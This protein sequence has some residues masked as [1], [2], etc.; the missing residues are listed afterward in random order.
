MKN[1]FKNLS[2]KKFRILFFT[3]FIILFC[4]L[5]FLFIEL[6]L[7]AKNYVFIEDENFFEEIKTYL[8]ISQ[9]Q[10]ENS[11]TEKLKFT[12]I[13][14]DDLENI[15]SNPLRK[16]PQKIAYVRLEKKLNF[17]NENFSSKVFSWELE[18]KNFVPAIEADFSLPKSKQKTIIS[19]DISLE[20]LP[21]EK[22]EGKK[23]ALPVEKKYLGEE[24]Y[25]L[26]EKTYL[27][28]T[29]LNEKF[30]EELKNFFDRKFSVNPETAPAE[31]ESL[32]GE[33]FSSS[34]EQKNEVPKQEDVPL[35]QNQN[36]IKNKKISFVA[37]VGDVMLSRGV[38]EIL[39]DEKLGIKSVFTNTLPV[40]QSNDIAICN[41]EGVLTDSWKNAI[42]TYTF[43]FKKENLK[44]LK[45]AGFNYF[46]QT[47][48]HS[49]DFGEEGF[50]DTLN[51]LKEF[52]CATSGVGFNADEAKKFYYKTVQNQKFAIISVGAFPVERSG[53]DGKKTA[54]ATSERAGI[55]WQ[56][57]EILK[58]VK[59]EA[60]NG[61]IVIV[62]VHGGEEYNFKPN[63]SQKKF[64]ES[65]I[66]CGASVVF[67]SHPHVLQ[68]TEFYKN[69]LIVYSLGN[70]IFNGMEDMKGATES[71][72]VRLG[73]YDK[74]IA[75]VEQFPCKID[76]KT[77]KLD[78]F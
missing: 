16:S 27:V 60:E 65:L 15:K 10:T 2:V 30:T 71:E 78:E 31:Q 14:F 45:D 48:N 44:A 70:F 13:S 3:S 43:K 28:L 21:I 41:L 59:L 74:K 68:P 9:S 12:F 58:E 17:Q 26:E 7:P 33:N 36:K 6:I 46:M 8:E 35:S 54:T 61:N 76:F 56:S 47:N 11:K 23:R 24:N 50:K 67:G 37:A 77:V 5:I 18:S 42:K 52:D 1:L 40:L 51:A 55:L 34:A 20:I 19:P 29:V 25:A 57:D 4:I 69:G 62:N 32:P 73:F 64:Y 39:L 53:F 22:L 66:D 75:Y 38:Q 63:A 49:Y 72:I